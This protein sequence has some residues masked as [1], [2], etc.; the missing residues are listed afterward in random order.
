M[1][2]GKTA[3]KNLNE[4]TLDKSEKILIVGLGVIGGSYADALNAGG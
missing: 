2:N 1:K 4:I 3:M